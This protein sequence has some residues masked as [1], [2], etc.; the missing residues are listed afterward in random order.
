MLYF[1]LGPARPRSKERHGANLDAFAKRRILRRRRVGEG[2]MPDKARAAVELRVEG[3]QHDDVLGRHAGEIPPAV[4]GR[5]AQDVVLAVAVA[6]VQ[7]ELEEIRRGGGRHVAHGER[8]LG[9]HAPDRFPHVEKGHAPREQGGRFV[10]A[11]QLPDAQRAGFGGVVAVDERDGGALRGA[12]FLRELFGRVAFRA[13]R[14]VEDEDA[15]RA[16][17]L[18]EEVDNLGVEFASHGGIIVPGL[19]RSLEAVQ[20]EAFL[21][22]GEGIGSMPAIVHGHLMR[23]VA[24]FVDR[25]FLR[26]VGLEEIQL[27]GLRDILRIIE[28]CS[29]V[30]GA[31]VSIWFYTVRVSHEFR[32]ICSASFWQ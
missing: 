15:V 27:R 10:V 18:L 21:V 14:V 31:L 8:V 28:S 2:G 5:V 13:D 19:V 30:L 20:R 25:G 12:G 9:D 17:G 23:I 4:G 26:G 24:R 7:V 32:L 29:N 22:D 11:E 3:F 1:P 16:L 6:V